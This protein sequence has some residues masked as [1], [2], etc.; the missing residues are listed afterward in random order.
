MTELGDA[1]FTL[2]D[3]FD[4]ATRFISWLGERR[5]VLAIDTETTGFNW[6]RDRIRL[7]QFGDG[8]HGWAV[9]F[10]QW[11]GLVGEV[12]RRYNGP[13]AMHNFTFDTLFLQTAGVDNIPLH[14]V[15][16][17]R[18]MAHLINP[19]RLTGLKALSKSLDPRA[20]AGQ[21]QLNALFKSHDVNWETVPIDHPSYW[22]YACLDTVLT[23]RLWESMQ[24]D[25]KPYAA[26]YDVEIT[27]Q[28]ALMEMQRKGIRY[29]EQ[30]TRDTSK[31]LRAWAHEARAWAI[32][33]YTEQMRR[34]N[35]DL[36]KSYEFNIG[37]TPQCAA[38]M[39]EDGW[40]P[41][42]YTAKGAPSMTKEVLEHVDHDLAKTI[43]KLKHSEKMASTYFD[44]FLELADGDLIHP[45]MNPLG[46]TTGRMTV[47]D[48]F[49]HGLPRDALVRDAFIPRDGNKLIM[50]DYD[51]MEVRILA[52]YSGDANLKAACD[53]GDI[54]TFTAQQIYKTEQITKL[55]RQLA[56]NSAYTI[57][58]GGGGIKLAATAGTTVAA[59]K[60]FMRLYGEQYPNI[61]PFRHKLEKSAAH[62]GNYLDVR[63]RHG[64]LQRASVDKPYVLTN[65][66]IQG[67]GAD[68]LKS[69]IAEL[70]LAGFGKYMVLPVHDEIVFDVPADDAEEIMHDAIDIMT[71]TTFDPTL[72][73]DG[74]IH[75]RWGDKYR[76]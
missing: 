12:L 65:Y 61:G 63:T 68:V 37:S 11:G 46:T 39:T 72:T 70:S 58:Y 42:S 31:R 69:K 50:I 74:Q 40:E 9:R 71:D 14:R 43:V 53:S 56:K 51:Q 20:A 30:Y 13:I 49:L 2:I 6:W 34:I 57:I 3:T 59:A 64:R 35:P 32:D 5:P 10:E 7:C 29:D 24:H 66:L 16:D 38:I 28:V 8:D 55:Q 52:H 27:A 19:A 60:E 75:D 21:D 54:H 1:K 47:T 4:D 48:P 73:V 33:T 62:N 18:T 41:E 36:P 17:T 22:A 67:T 45:K 44:N 25:I 23:A 26:L 15:D 76:E